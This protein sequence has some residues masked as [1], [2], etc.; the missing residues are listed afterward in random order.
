MTRTQDKGLD[1]G[2]NTQQP[3]IIDTCRSKYGKVFTRRY[4]KRRGRT[5][6][7]AKEYETLLRDKAIRTYIADLSSP[8][9][10]LDKHQQTLICLALVRFLIRLSKPI[11]ASA[12]SELVQFKK[13]H[14]ND[15]SLEQELKLWKAENNRPGTY[16]MISRVLGVFH[17]NFARL[18]M[19]IHFPSS[20][21]HTKPISEPTLR[22]IWNDLTPGDRDVLDLMA[23][24]AERRNALNMLPLENVHLAENSNV[25][26]LE[27]PSR[28]SKTGIQ[29]P[30]IIPKGLAERLLDDATR[31]GYT[32]LVPNYRTVWKRITKLAQTTYHVRLTSHYLRKRFETIA[33]RIPS[34]EMNPNHWVILMGSKPM[35]GHMPDIYSLLSNTELIKEY[36][37][38]LMPR[39]ALTG[40]TSKSVNT[41]RMPA[42]QEQFDRLQSQL[43]GILELLEGKKASL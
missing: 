42:T 6:P 40:Q 29:H 26:I 18:Q 3:H 37:T 15:T 17:R 22:A 19:T 20:S 1:G 14:P 28:L 8:E 23:Y 31:N 5:S 38:Y 34:N 39:L 25:A 35:L 24:G 33:E 10:P 21:N 12:V 32:V 43:S 2:T 4:T 7:Y 11:S 27:V 41:K 9:K 36:E 30:S 16:A 13:E